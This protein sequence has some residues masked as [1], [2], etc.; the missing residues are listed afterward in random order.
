MSKAA[1]HSVQL[2]VDAELIDLQRYALQHDYHRFIRKAWGTIEPGVEFVDG[3]PIEAVT[4][5]VQSLIEGTL[6]QRNLLINIPPRC[7]KSTSVSV[8]LVPWVWSRP[9]WAHLKFLYTSYA[10]ELSIRDSV[11]A[12]MLMASPWYQRHFGSQFHLTSDAKIRLTNS[13]NGYRIA[14]S[15]TGQGTGEGGDIIVAD[16]PHNAKEAESDA[17]RT[18]TVQ[19]WRETMSTR[20]ND[21]KTVKRIVV[22][23]RLH[24]GDLSGHVLAEEFSDYVHLCLPMRYEPQVYAFGKRPMVRFKDPRKEGEL[25]WPERFDEAETKKLERNLGPYGAAG[26]FQQRPAPRGGG[27]VKTSELRLWAYKL[28]LPDIEFVVQS[29]D[30]ALTER[31][32]KNPDPDDTACLALG[33][34]T[35]KGQRHAIVLDAWNEKMAYPT[36]RRK[37][38]AEWKAVYGG[39]E[40][41]DL[42]PGRR[43][44]NIIVENKG[45]GI[46]VLQDLR[47]AGVPCF[48]YNPGQADKTARLQQ[49][50][51]L[52]EAGHLWL[53]ES[54]KEPGQPIAWVRDAVKQW[55][56]F[57]AAKHDDYVDCLTQAM[58]Y[59]RD[60]GLLDL[61]EVE[62]DIEEEDYSAAKHKRAINNPYNQ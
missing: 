47:A 55:T 38:L 1:Q 19:W 50:L 37:V 35:Y 56:T 39:K 10:G 4:D 57:P 54:R 30:T 62:E 60:L 17:V 36:L 15:V 12:R 31:T 51:P 28:P 59:L 22:M 6:G 14:T 11:K 29:Y 46:S 5:H 27:M 2:C 40:A 9:E 32:N 24:E 61:E 7:M 41:D 18:Y 21:P 49:V 20:G 13:R 45:S 44:D 23:Q 3:M 25:L 16:D 43:P 34:F 42:H 33:I 53:L 48:S 26:Q 52:I 58:I 8:A